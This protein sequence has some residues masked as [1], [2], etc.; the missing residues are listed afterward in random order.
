[1]QTT[2]CAHCGRAGGTVNL[3]WRGKYVDPQGVT[4]HE[5]KNG[6]SWCGPCEESRVARCAAAAVLGKLGGSRPKPYSAEEREKRRVRLAGFREPYQ[7]AR[8]AAK[9]ARIMEEHEARKAEVAEGQNG[10][11]Y[12]SVDTVMVSAPAEM[13]AVMTE[14]AP[15]GRGDEVA[16]VALPMAPE[17]TVDG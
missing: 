3:D 13:A 9:A 2:D 15:E 16:P 5:Q 8:R 11:A 7:A 4:W 12:I 14:P 17:A 6:D 1:M 10:Q